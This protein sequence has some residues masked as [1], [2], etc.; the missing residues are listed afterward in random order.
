MSLWTWS[1]PS[2]LGLLSFVLVVVAIL[3]FFSTPGPGDTFQGLSTDDLSH[4]IQMAYPLSEYSPSSTASTTDASVTTAQQS[5][6]KRKVTIDPVPTNIPTHA[7]E[8]DANSSCPSSPELDTRRQAFT[9]PPLPPDLAQ[10]KPAD[11]RNRGKFFHEECCRMILEMIYA[12]PFPNIRPNFLES[13]K[14]NRN[15]ELDGYNDDL[16]VA[17]E[18]HGPQHYS[19]PNAFHRTQEEHFEQKCRDNYKKRRCQEV[20]IYLIIIPYHI[21]STELPSFI[22]AR[23]PEHQQ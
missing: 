23:L 1:T 11:A 13:P 17:F 15:L 19:F 21:D 20:G 3:W 12:V 18:Y 16:G 14:T 7:Q 5:T 10:W 22:W 6:P 8:S 4:A 9:V 2:L